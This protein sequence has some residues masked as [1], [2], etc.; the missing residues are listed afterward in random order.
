M[1]FANLDSPV[2]EMISRVLGSELNILKNEGS[3]NNLIG[4]SRTLLDLNRSHEAAVL[5]LGIGQGS[6]VALLAKAAG[7]SACFRPDLAGI[8][9][10]IILARD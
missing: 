2:K 9:R 10:A 4:L 7:F 3:E 5:E 8:E 6:A 1:F